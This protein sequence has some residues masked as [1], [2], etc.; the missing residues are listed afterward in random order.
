MNRRG[1]FGSMIAGLAAACGYKVE[2]KV[3]I[4]TGRTASYTV[5]SEDAENWFDQSIAVYQHANAVYRKAEQL[6]AE[7][8]KVLLFGDPTKKYFKCIEVK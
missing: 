4:G 3:E 8:K 5:L 7:G 2:P 6:Q 1:F